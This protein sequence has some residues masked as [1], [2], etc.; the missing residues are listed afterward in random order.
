MKLQS[1]KFVFRRQLT[2]V[3]SLLHSHLVKIVAL[4]FI[5]FSAY[6]QALVFGTAPQSQLTVGSWWTFNG[7][8]KE[9]GN[10]TGYDQ[11]Y[12]VEKGN[13][14]GRFEVASGNASMIVIR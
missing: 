9:Y 10:G 5:I 3:L 7:N 1:V 6:Q 11:G 14:T 12:Y 8:Y 4:I 2:L 13:F